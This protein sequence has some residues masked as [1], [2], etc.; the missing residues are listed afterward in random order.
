MYYQTL[1]FLKR[2]IWKPIWK[3]FTYPLRLKKKIDCYK[4]NYEILKSLVDVRT[5]HPAKGLIRDVQMRNYDFTKEIIHEL[6]DQSLHPFMIYGTLLGA[7]RHKGFI[8]WDDDIDFGLIRDEYEKVFQLAK[9]KYIV[10]YQQINKYNYLASAKKRIKELLQIYPNQTILLV[11]P[12]LCK[13]IKGSSLSNYVQMDLFSFDY[14]SENYSYSDFIKNAISTQGK[15]WKINNTQREVEFL[16][17]QRKNNSNIVKESSKIFYGNDCI[18]AQNIDSLKKK[19]TNFMKTADFFPLK[20]MQFE[21]TEFWAPNNHI[22]ILEDYFGE[23]WCSIPDNI[24][25]PHINERD[26]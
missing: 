10:V 8:P 19:Y 13:F 26:E 18:E 16:A 2:K 7:E 12:F 15:L 14:Y 25:P 9:T 20:R 11:Y 1:R 4:T 17:N 22:K 24:L 23:N 5:L 3:L 6:E 21:N